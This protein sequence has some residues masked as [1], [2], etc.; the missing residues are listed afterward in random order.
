MSCSPIL[1]WKSLICLSSSSILFCA[2]ISSSPPRP[3]AP[4]SIPS[5][6][7]T[8]PE[9][10]TV[11]LTEKEVREKALPVLIG[12][13]P[14]AASGRALAAGEPDGYV[15]VIA[16]KETKK[17]LGAGIVGPEASDLISEAALAVRLGATLGDIA[18]TV[19]PHPT[20]PEA[21]H[22]ACEAAMGQAIHVLAPRSQTAQGVRS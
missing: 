3:L 4:S 16:D 14:F 20:L 1:A 12:R 22:E 11:G 19:H 6:I 7:F 5:A 9:V 2:W 10:A 21:F 18:S 8:D 13:F 15:K 17:I